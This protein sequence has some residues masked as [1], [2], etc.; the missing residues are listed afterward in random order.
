MDR[1]KRYWESVR[2]V[3]KE[4]DQQFPGG[5]LFVTPVH[6]PA[7]NF[8]GGDA[9]QV[10]PSIAAKGIVEGRFRVSTESEIVT[11]HRHGQERQ[12]ITDAQNLRATG[13]VKVILSPARG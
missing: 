12:S 10:E 9:V 7:Q 6:D 3:Q 1:L 5:S 11:C 4:L 8:F 13:M 2:A